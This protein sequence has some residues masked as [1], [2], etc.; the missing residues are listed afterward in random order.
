MVA[1]DFV[2]IVSAK[3][4]PQKMQKTGWTARKSENVN[5]PIF[6]DFPLTGDTQQGAQSLRSPGTTSYMWTIH[7]GYAYS[8]HNE[9][10]TSRSMY[11]ENPVRC[12][13]NNN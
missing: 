3:N 10:I 7:S 6:T 1:A 2:G 12:M 13:R 5:A 8:I 4:D 11:D 9:S